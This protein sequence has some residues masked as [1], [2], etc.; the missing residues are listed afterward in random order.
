MNMSDGLHEVFEGDVQ[1][2]YA[3][4]GESNL[5]HIGK[6]NQENRRDYKYTCPYCQKDLRPFL[7]RGKK[8]SKRSHFSHKNGERCDQDGYI[9]TTAKRL[10]KEKWDSDEPFEITMSVRME[11]TRVDS[12][13]FCQSIGNRCSFG[14]IET[15]NLKEY[16][17]QC[18]VEKKYGAFI[19]D[20]CLID[21]NEKHKPIF[22][23]IWSKHKNS[24]KKANSSHKIIEIRL[25][26]IPE[27][28][29]LPQH[30]IT[31]SESVSF[32]H[33]KILKKN[34]EASDGPKL[35]KFILYGD[36]LKSYIDKEKTTCSNYNTRHHRKAVLEIVGMCDEIYT[37]TDFRWLCTAIAIDKGY[38]IR[39]CYIC[40]KYGED[41][42]ALEWDNELG[43]FKEP[44]SGCRR[45]LK[46]QGI[47]P[48]KP[49]DAKTCEQFILKDY[50]LK[51][52]MENYSRVTLYIWERHSDG[53]TGEEIRYGTNSLEVDEE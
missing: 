18:L 19:P 39:S 31:E 38:K 25:K 27:L 45:D 26:T 1:Y 6:V 28:E 5:L 7:S 42:S 29:E 49:D 35:M 41:R 2:P 22:I 15:Y 4:V 11:C 33:F 30:P 53:T 24:E 9:H 8:N 43:R 13:L 23:E 3:D 17:T 10:L 21:E 46:K 12:C 37:L 50:P 14:K 36:T 47:L 51:S 34:P 44:V 40:R 20:L 52:I 48:C 16:Y 32:N